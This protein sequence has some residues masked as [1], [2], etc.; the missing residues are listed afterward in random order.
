VVRLRLLGLLAL[1][2]GMLAVP[3]TAAALDATTTG[4]ACS[5]SAP[6]T[7]T[8]TTCTATV[9]DIESTPVGTPG[10]EVSFSASPDSGTFPSP[11]ACTLDA[12]GSCQL[13]FTPA[14]GGVYTITASYGGDANHSGSSGTGSVTAV[15][16]TTT[17]LSC[18]PATVQI[19]SSTQCTATLSDPTATQPPLG[20]INFSSSPT[21]GTFGASGVCP[22]QPSKSGIGG[23]ATCAVTFTPSVAGP[24]AITADYGGDSTHGPSSGAFGLTATTTPSGGGPGSHGGGGGTLTI[25]ISS[26][27]PPAG[28][29]TI[30]A[31]A[32]V[33]RRHAAA[34]GL[35]C[36]GASGSSCVG[37]LTFT[38]RAKVKVRVK[39]PVRAK[40]HSKKGHK[41]HKTKT[42]IE[43]KS[44]TIVVGS[45]TYSLATKHSQAFT[46]KLSK[47][48]VKLLAKARG[49][50]LK[51]QVWS[52]GAVV[53]TVTLQGPK[54]KKH[55][56]HRK[57]K[58]HKKK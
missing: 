52:G 7:G 40:H 20:S 43:T 54:H 37:A 45:L 9:T 16:V 56:R 30:A 12:A 24:Y 21:T 46:F 48:A 53:K 44:T 27:P 47:A 31:S 28:K 51:V 32:R 6:A 22:W 2:V 10:G 49:G 5:P 3:S 34:L 33:S 41:G 55:K 8:A 19:G 58:R 36:T 39:V 38:R 11:S 1:M 14:T 23:S 29:V 50:R 26:G 42:K 17:S 57:H 15:D 25:V 18:A 13:S 35:S 4:V